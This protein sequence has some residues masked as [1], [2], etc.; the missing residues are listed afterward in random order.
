[1]LLITRS[2]S[3]SEHLEELSMVLLTPENFAVNSFL[4][5]SSILFDNLSFSSLSYLASTDSLV[6]FWVDHEDSFRLEI[7]IFSCELSFFSVVISFSCSISLVSSNPSWVPVCPWR[8]FSE[9]PDFTILVS[10]MHYSRSFLLSSNS[11]WF[12]YLSYLISWSSL[13]VSHL[14]SACFRQM[15]P[16]KHFLIGPFTPTIDLF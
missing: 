11:F 3:H 15:S 2:L 1:M 7:C 14:L 4:S 13:F 10:L 16:K 6:C 9:I 5:Y 8:Q 12:L